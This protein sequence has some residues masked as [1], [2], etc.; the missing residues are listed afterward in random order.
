MT[1]RMKVSGFCIKSCERV[2]GGL[3]LSFIFFASF[4]IAALLLS[5]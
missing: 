3:S 5:V 1:M 4:S 2:L